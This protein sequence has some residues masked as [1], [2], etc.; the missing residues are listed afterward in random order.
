MSDMPRRKR[1]EYTP[2]QKADAV[3]LVHETE[4]VAKVARDLDL[5]ESSLRNWV[6]QAEIDGVGGADGALT[7][8]ERTQAAAGVPSTPGPFALHWRSWGSGG[9]LGALATVHAT[10]AGGLGAQAQVVLHVSDEGVQFH[11]AAGS[12]A[13]AGHAHET[14]GDEVVL[15]AVEAGAALGEA[16]GGDP[17]AL[18]VELRQEAALAAAHGGDVGEGLGVQ[19]GRVAALVH[20]QEQ[21]LGSQVAGSGQGAAGTEGVE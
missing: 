17:G 11:Q 18:T 5:T 7:T 14:A 1:R 3:R 10:A 19:E 16:L 2:Q 15:D 12:L 8:D 9:G 4:S 13:D 20:A 6:K 21:D